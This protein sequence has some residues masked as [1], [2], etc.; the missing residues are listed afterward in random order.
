MF[1]GTVTCFS[2]QKTKYSSSI[3][4]LSFLKS[5]LNVSE[6]PLDSIVQGVWIKNYFIWF[7]LKLMVWL[8]SCYQPCNTL[9]LFTKALVK[10]LVSFWN[11]LASEGKTDEIHLKRIHQTFEYCL[12]KELLDFF[13][14]CSCTKT[15]FYNHFLPQ[16]LLRCY[17]GIINLDHSGLH[18]SFHFPHLELELALAVAQHSR[19]AFWVRFSIIGKV[20]TRK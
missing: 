7:N 9:H 19:R 12:D 16:C 4:F 6:I 17:W 11:F 2:F 1:F 5:L 3:W 18:Q 8:S 20:E 13:S 14:F 15:R 10:E